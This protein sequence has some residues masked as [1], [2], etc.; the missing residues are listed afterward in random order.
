MRTRWLFGVA[1]A[2]ALASGCLGTGSTPAGACP[3]FDDA[4]DYQEYLRKKWSSQAEHSKKN[5]DAV[6][7]GVSAWGAGRNEEP[8]AR[9]ETFVNWSDY[10]SPDR[11]E[12]FD[13]VLCISL[14][15]IE[16][17]P[18]LSPQF[19]TTTPTS[20]AIATQAMDELRNEHLRQ[21]G[22]WKDQCCYILYE[23]RFFGAG[24][25]FYAGTNADGSSSHSP[26]DAC[27]PHPPG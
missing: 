7:I 3:S 6:E 25:G 27:A 19:S 13:D 23:D 2:S 1:I 18:T 12:I 11:P 14:W 15:R 17:I 10:N 21:T 24:C 26:E 22:V 16:N 5:F 20:A 9:P 8:G 4:E